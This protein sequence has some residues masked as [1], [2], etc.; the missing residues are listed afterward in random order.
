MNAE[1]MQS[2]LTRIAELFD[3]ERG[4][5]RADNLNRLASLFDGLGKAKVSSVVTIIL[6]N[7]KSDGRVPCHPSGLRE[8]VAGI[9]RLF[10]QSGAKVQA[11][12]FGDLLKLLSGA[13]NQPADAFIAE[14]VAARVKRP[15]RRAARAKPQFTMETA[16]KLASELTSAADDRMRF[17]TLLDQLERQC[18]AAELKTIAG[19]Y[20][21][22]E[23]AKTKKDDIIRAIR[24]WHREDE[25]NR[26]RRASQAKTAL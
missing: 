3:L 6:G 4:F 21:G 23:T 7:W 8:I 15:P 16:R 25:L 2:A 22:Y 19:L 1:Q 14:A 20:T 18:K 9:Q 26:D 24:H 5:E 11:K 13:G 17:D 12:A 10:E